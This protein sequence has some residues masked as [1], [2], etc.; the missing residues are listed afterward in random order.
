VRVERSKKRKEGSKIRITEE[1]GSKFG[2]SD[3]ISRED[4]QDVIHSI[5]GMDYSLFRFCCSFSLFTPD[6]IVRTCVFL[7]QG[8]VS[9]FVTDADKKR[10]E[11]LSSLFSL[12]A[13]GPAMKLARESRKVSELEVHSLEKQLAGIT[14]S[15]RTWQSLNPQQETKQWEDQKA[16]R[17]QELKG[18]ILSERAK[19]RNLLEAPQGKEGHART[20]EEMANEIQRLEAETNAIN[21]AL[22]EVGKKYPIPD[23]MVKLTDA[24]AREKQIS[25]N[26]HV[27]KE[28][29][30]T[31]SEAQTCD[32][33]GQPLPEENSDFVLSKLSADLQVTQEKDT[34]VKHEMRGL[35]VQLAD[36]QRQLKATTGGLESA[37]RE[38]QEMLTSLSRQQRQAQSVESQIRLFTSKLEEVENSVN[39]YVNSM[40]QREQ[41]ISRLEVQQDKKKV[42]LSARSRELRMNSFWEEGFGH[43]GLPVQVLHEVSHFLLCINNI[44]SFFRCYLSCRI[45]RINTYRGC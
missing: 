4:S 34:A 13:C 45:M 18:A 41:E 26:L 3:K 9:N 31:V 12:T 23:L 6:T 38:A 1:A 42:E 21:R 19:L 20:G 35:S 30:E 27:I 33:C 29:I 36:M 44:Y 5:V 14:S 25:N 37:L 15:L 11:L 39:P 2:L 7:G 28:R 43:M 32:T 40:A 16:S 22:R 10:K 8:E 24:Q 17:L